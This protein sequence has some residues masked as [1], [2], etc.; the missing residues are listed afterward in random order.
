MDRRGLLKGTLAAAG[1]LAFFGATAV[2]ARALARL[3][4]GEFLW[5]PEKSPSGPVAIIVSLPDQLVHVYRGG[6]RIGLSTCSTGKK[7][8]STPTGVFT[9][10]EKDKHHH[11]ST[12][13]NA[14][15]PNMNRLTWSGVALHAGNLPGYPASH[16]CVRLPLKFSEKLFTVTHVARRSS[17]PTITAS[18]PLSLILDRSSPRSLRTR[19]KPPLQSRR[20][21]SRRSS[22]TKTCSTRCLLLISRK[23]REL[24]VLKDGN[25]VAKGPIEIDR[26]G[27]PFGSYVFVLVAPHESGRSATWHAI[28]HTSGPSASAEELIG[29]VQSGQKLAQ[30]VAGLMHPG[31]VLVMTDAPLH[32]T[33]RTERGFVVMTHG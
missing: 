10:L 11:S 29:R 8:H 2:G 22:A 4:P 9:I 21:P 6:V 23:D 33:T 32:S 12:Y 24:Y 18:R 13:N 16:G 1:S 28:R 5:T 25:V 19:C 27:D 20:S 15:M 14:P 7:G 3:K 30:Q 17:S 26:P 31:L